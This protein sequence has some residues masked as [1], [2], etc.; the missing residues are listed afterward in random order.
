MRTLKIRKLSE[1][2]MKND[3]SVVWLEQSL[4][5]MP[6]LLELLELLLCNMKEMSQGSII[7]QY[8]R[9]MAL[10]S[11]NSFYKHN[12]LAFSITGS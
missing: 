12:F 10:N 7:F 5:S 4:K 8:N 2:E 1:K 6:F 11:P 9:G 3:R